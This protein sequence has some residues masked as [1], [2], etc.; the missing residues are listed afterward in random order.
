MIGLF[1]IA[2]YLGIGALCHVFFVGAHFDWSSA[3]TLVWLFAW[4]VMLF[5]WF[6]VFVA[7]FILVALIV[8]GILAMMGK[9]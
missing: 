8:V 3:W 2:I 1:R 6:W 9:V 5:I 4:P 7:A